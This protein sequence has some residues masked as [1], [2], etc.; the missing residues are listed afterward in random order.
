MQAAALRVGI[1]LAP[2]AQ[3]VGRL[4]SRRP[5]ANPG[6]GP[7]PPPPMI[8]RARLRVPFRISVS[9]A[10]VLITTPLILG[11]IGILYPRNAQLARD[12]ATELPLLLWT[13]PKVC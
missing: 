7:D 1:C 9:V 3:A 8:G 11:I 13:I 10:S 2:R 4:Q 6:S 12:L 5:W